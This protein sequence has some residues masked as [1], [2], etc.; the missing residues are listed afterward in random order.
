[1]TTKNYEVSIRL[2]SGTLVVYVDLDASASEDEIYDAAT[3]EIESQV[4]YA[5]LEGYS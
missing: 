2:D 5:K 1:M 3:A 4:A